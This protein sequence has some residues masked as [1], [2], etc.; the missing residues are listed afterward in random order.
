[1]AIAYVT[2]PHNSTSDGAAATEAIL[3]ITNPTGPENADVRAVNA[4]AIAAGPAD[5]AV[6]ITA[7]APPA[8]SS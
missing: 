4:A 8:S 6:H 2:L 3:P 1:M 7:N 5:P